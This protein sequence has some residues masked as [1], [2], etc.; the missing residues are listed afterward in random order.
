MIRL[1]TLPSSGKGIQVTELSCFR[2]KSG[3]FST[4]VKEPAKYEKRERKEKRTR[5]E[6]EE[7]RHF[8]L[9]K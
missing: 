3:S 8:D 2:V 7:K 5:R 1:L 4:V 6:Q 9:Q